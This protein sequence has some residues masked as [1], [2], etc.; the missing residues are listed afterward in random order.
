MNEV[1]V[2]SEMENLMTEKREKKLARVEAALE[3]HGAEP[4]A[5]EAAAKA[6]A[7]NYTNES[8]WPVDFPFVS[9]AT[10]CRPT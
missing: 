8:V 2:N 4:G 3:W 5:K 6:R 7:G 9:C 1:G 10:C